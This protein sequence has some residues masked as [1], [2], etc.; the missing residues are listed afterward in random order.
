[1]YPSVNLLL[2]GGGR[3]GGRRREEDEEWTALSLNL[4]ATASQ[5][6]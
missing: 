1:M 5:V 2:G 3:K 4:I 6:C